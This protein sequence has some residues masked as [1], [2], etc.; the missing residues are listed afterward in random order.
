MCQQ[1]LRLVT[2]FSARPAEKAPASPNRQSLAELTKLEIPSPGGFFSGLSP[3][4]RS[5][6]HVLAKT[7]DGSPP[8][9]STTAEQFYRCPWNAHVAGRPAPKR[10]GP[11]EDYYRRFDLSAAP[12]ERVVEVRDDD[13]SDEMPTARP[14]FHQDSTSSEET[15]KSPSSL[16]LQDAPVEIVVDYDPDYARKQQKIALSNLDRTELWLL[17]QRAYLKG[18]SNIAESSLDLKAVDQAPD[19]GRNDEVVELQPRLEQDTPL[20][21]KVVRFSDMSSPAGKPINLPPK[22]LQQESAYYRAFRT[23]VVKARRRD[24]FVYQLARFEALQA[25]RVAL[26]K[27]HRNQLL[28]KY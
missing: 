24:V 10:P 22:K 9:T 15:V 8:P 13:V 18:I 28:G 1:P 25:Q 20:Q 2:S 19:V 4:T 12:V 5:T 6:W 14:V 7:P 21:K 3:R 16:R 23:Y 26:R 27:M 17:A 11:A